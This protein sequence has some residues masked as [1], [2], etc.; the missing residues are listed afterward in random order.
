MQLFHHRLAAVDGS[1]SSSSSGGSG[2]LPPRSNF[3]SFHN[4]FITV[5]QVLSGDNW[6]AVFYN[7]V[8]GIGWGWPVVYFVS[9]VLLGKYV[10]RKASVRCGCVVLVCVWCVCLGE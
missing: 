4:A 8:N 9:W 2:S 10:M 7:A 6:H 1:S 3:D 5:F